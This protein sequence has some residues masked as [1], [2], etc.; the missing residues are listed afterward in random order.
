MLARAI[1]FI[2]LSDSSNTFTAGNGNDTVSLTSSSQNYLELGG[3]NDFIIANNSWGHTIK[4]G[5]N[6][7]TGEN[8]VTA[9]SS[10]DFIIYTANGTK[11]LRNMNSFV[12][13]GGTYY[14]NLEVSD[15]ATVTSSTGSSVVSSKSSTV[16]NGTSGNDTITTTNF[17]DVARAVYGNAGDDLIQIKEV[18][19]DSIYNS[20]LTLSG[21]AGNDTI[22]VS[23]A[24]YYN[25]TLSING[26]DGADVIS[27]D[28]I[29]RN[30]TIV[31]GAGD[32]I[33]LDTGSVNYFFDRTDAVTINGVT[34]KSNTA[35]TS[36]N[37]QNSYKGMTIGTGFS[38]N[39]TVP[40]DKVLRDTYGNILATEGTYSLVNG[41]FNAP[42]LLWVLPSTTA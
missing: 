19:H 4:I 21:G 22:S 28:F 8:Y 41:K 37:I 32:N 5:E 38:G 40:S 36:S 6:Y 13:I 11:T 42:R 34:F 25:S 14:F 3:G 7:S 27:I 18:N 33:S 26:G 29:D 17:K 35:N 16:A 24:I 23:G 15:W 30:T 2:S 1:N 20:N 39:I 9:R 31:A 10:N 12:L